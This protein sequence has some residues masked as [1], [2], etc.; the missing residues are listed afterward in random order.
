MQLKLFF[1]CKPKNG[2]TLYN[3]F[4]DKYVTHETKV[5][6]RLIDSLVLIVFYSSLVDFYYIGPYLLNLISSIKY[7]CNSKEIKAKTINKNFLDLN[8]M[9]SDLIGFFNGFTR[10]LCQ[11]YNCYLGSE[12]IYNERCF[13]HL[14]KNNNDSILVICREHSGSY[15][16]N[17]L[18]SMGQIIPKNRNVIH[19]DENEKKIEIKNKN[20]INFIKFKK[21]WKKKIY[22]GI[23]NFKLEQN[24]EYNNNANETIN[25]IDVS[26]ITNNLDLPSES[27]ILFDEKDKDKNII[28]E[29]S[30]EIFDFINNVSKNNNNKKEIEYNNKSHYIEEKIYNNK[31]NEKNNNDLFFKYREYKLNNNKIKN[32]CISKDENECKLS[33]EENEGIIQRNKTQKIV[34][35]NMELIK[36]INFEEL[37]NDE[38]NDNNNNYDV[39]NKEKKKYSD[40]EKSLRNSLTNN[41]NQINNH[42]IE[43]NLNYLQ[44]IFNNNRSINNINYF[45]RN[46]INNSKS[47]INDNLIYKYISQDN[48]NSDDQCQNSNNQ[49]N[50]N[51]YVPTK[52]NILNNKENNEHKNSSNNIFY[53]IQ[54]KDINNNN[55]QSLVNFQS[56]F[57]NN[58]Y[59]NINRNQNKNEF[60]QY[61]LSFLGGYTKTNDLSEDYLKINKSNPSIISELKEKVYYCHS[62]SN[63]NINKLFKISFKGYIGIN[64]KPPNI[65]N[66]KI[67][68][69]N[70][71]NE[72]WKDINYFTE[73]NINKNI[74]KITDMIYKIQLQ[75]QKD[76]IKL[77]TYSLNHNILFQT[78]K[79]DTIINLYNNL[80][81]YKFNYIQ[82]INKFIQRIEIIVEFKNDYMG[83]KTA[84]SD[85][86][87]I[88]NNGFKINV[89]YN[90]SVN[91]GKIKFE[92]NDKN[93][94]KMINYIKKIS[95]MIQLKNIVISNMNIKINYS[96][97][98]NQSPE[99]LFNRK[100]SLISFQYE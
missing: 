8:T 72:Q 20:I 41:F 59:N 35:K 77:M 92:N 64:I 63:S 56:S 57:N 37:N 23:N 10:A 2:F 14:R 40:Y 69:L 47:N 83:W 29:E 88:N 43:Y 32:S 60:S 98:N 91:E 11:D 94:F 80:L 26:M 74:E 17:Q 16:F 81:I 42:Y 84:K 7:V 86:N 33:E 30:L 19:N 66:K 45:K 48:N 87:I 53:P 93:N 85:G 46:S 18:K 3:L 90:G 96:N 24:N 44:T 31:K 58:Q 100:I 78:K 38:N 13:L 39:N 34:S 22:F 75:K 28:N 25:K 49:N 89:V 70:V 68:Y 52:N 79:I 51:I 65:I 4:E 54:N 6:L 95:I 1:Q 50:K 99:T 97:S 71:L 27:Q 5:V 76:A 61:D 9:I 67:F 73:R 62:L 15:D 55:F 21:I 36:N 82:Q 12:A